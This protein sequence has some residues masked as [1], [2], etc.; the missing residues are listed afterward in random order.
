MPCYLVSGDEPLLVTEAMDAIRA[1]ART[2]GFDSRDLYIQLPGFDWDELLRSA[3]ALSLFA[4]RRIVELRLPSGKP[5]RDGSA[6]IAELAGKAGDDLLVLVQTPKLDRNSA[7]AKWVKALE[8]HGVLVQVWPVGT[9]DLPGWIGTRMQAAGLK[10][11]REAVRLIA[12]RVE[13]NLL[14]AQ[15]EIE[16]LRLINGEGPVTAEDVERAV[17]D[18]SR[19]D[20]FQL[21]DAAIAGDASRALRMLEGLRAEG[22]SEVVVMWA[23]TRE[24]RVLAQLADGIESGENLGSAMRRM[25]VWDKRQNMMRA[26]VSRHSRQDFHT[27]IKLCGDADAAAKGQRDGD[28][29]LKATNLVWRLAGQKQAA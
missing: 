1:A 19:F 13:G 21:V 3:G 11:D 22:V 29:W 5:G 26:C 9:R 12:D 7:S 8:S 28:A 14:A 17:A 24:I 25:R 2:Q 6:A 23:L 10:P 15:Q 16:K 4:D 18:S 20:V 27:L